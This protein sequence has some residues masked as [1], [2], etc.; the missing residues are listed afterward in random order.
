MVKETITKNEYLMVEGLL[1]LRDEN[2]KQH[3]YIQAAIASIVGETEDGDNYYGLVSDYMW[4][5]SGA[6][7]LLK[8][9]DIKIKKEGKNGKTKKSS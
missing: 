3:N 6:K 1:V 8:N 2:I 7:Q 4:E 5:E 9:L